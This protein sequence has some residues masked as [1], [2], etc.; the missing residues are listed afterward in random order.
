MMR[1][2]KMQNKISK[3][4]ISIFM[5]TFKDLCRLSPI[6]HSTSVKNA[7]YF[8]YFSGCREPFF[9]GIWWYLFPFNKPLND[10]IH[11]SN[12]YFNDLPYVWWLNE[13][14]QKILSKNISFVNNFYTSNSVLAM[15]TTLNKYEHL[16][17][18]DSKIITIEEVKNAQA[19]E[20]WLDLYFSIFDFNEKDYS[21]ITKSLNNFGPNNPY[22][23]LLA[24]YKTKPAGIMSLY[25]NKNIAYICKGAVLKQFRKKGIGTLLGKV[26]KKKA[27]EKKVKIISAMLEPS[28]EAKGIMDRLGFK[29]YF[30]IYP[31]FHKTN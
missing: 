27:I 2:H 26:C 24:K 29:E 31:N 16:P 17:S 21:I 4:I 11:Q 9:N 25:I 10:I 7:Y 6:E 15:A 19:F 1:F 5:E 14:N 13:R 3:Q 8:K 18:I 28:R 23:H 22:I 12:S 30:T 20:I